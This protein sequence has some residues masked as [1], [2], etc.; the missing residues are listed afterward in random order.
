MNKIV[1]AISS[2][3]YSKG[4]GVPP[5]RMRIKDNPLRHKARERPS[6][7]KFHTQSLRFRDGQVNGRTKELHLHPASRN[8]RLRRAGVDHPPR[9]L[10]QDRRLQLRRP[11]SRDHRREE[12][13]PRRLRTAA[14][15][16]ASAVLRDEDGGGAEGASGSGPAAA[17][18]GGRPAGG[19]GGGS[20]GVVHSGGGQSPA[21]DEEGGADAGG[22]FSGAQAAD[23]VG[24]GFEFFVEQWSGGNV[25]GIQW[26]F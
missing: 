26:V 20:G 19:G 5:R 16:G 12:E 23:L 3:R 17:G 8:Q 15:E 2:N 25:I 7:P 1:W 18:G 4:S 6:G 21:A 11:A 10:R 22:G 13:L 9:N 14:G 24:D